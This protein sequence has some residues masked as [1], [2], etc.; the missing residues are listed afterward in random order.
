MNNLLTAKVLVSVYNGEHT[1][2]NFK[3]TISAE[4]KALLN[5]EFKG[6]LHSLLN[7]LYHKGI[8]FKSAATAIAMGTSKDY[9]IKEY[10]VI[11][12]EGYFSLDYKGKQLH[13]SKEEKTM[14]QEQMEFDL[15]VAVGTAQD[16]TTEGITTEKDLIDKFFTTDMTTGEYAE[17][18]KALKDLTPEEAEAVIVEAFTTKE[19]DSNVRPELAGPIHDEF[20]ILL[21]ENGLFDPISVNGLLY[22]FSTRSDE[23][24]EFAIKVEKLF[25]E[26]EENYAK[27]FGEIANQEG[28]VKA[29]AKKVVYVTADTNR[30]AGD[31]VEKA[32]IAT[33]KI[34]NKYGFQKPADLLDKLAKRPE[35]LKE[36]NYVVAMNHARKEKKAEKKEQVLK[37][38]DKAITANMIMSYIKAKKTNKATDNQ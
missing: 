37:G 36:M 29:V 15:E 23:H 30:V 33:A 26:S 20:I 11:D 38:A 16:P 18:R 2:E 31:V 17:L 10:T 34:I 1:V 32:I 28:K 6:I 35:E 9:A 4:N 5:A 27:Y 14:K 19:E 25:E 7:K 13:I 12:N 24:K 21:Q 22:G 8:V 3:G